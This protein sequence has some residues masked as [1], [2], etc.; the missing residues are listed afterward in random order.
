MTSAL[1]RF[2]ALKEDELKRFRLWYKT[3]LERVREARKRDGEALKAQIAEIKR[4]DGGELNIPRCSD[5]YC[6][7]R[8]YPDS[9][10]DCALLPASCGWSLKLF[11]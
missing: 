9:K 5:Y 3:D 1:Q 10:M 11:S 6:L 4:Y 7:L 8:L 2:L